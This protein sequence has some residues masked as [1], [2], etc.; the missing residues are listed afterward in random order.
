MT[1]FKNV[2]EIKEHLEAQ[3]EQIFT[4]LKEIVSF[5]SV[6]SEPTLVE[7]Y[8]GATNWTRD[9][10]RNAGFEVSEHLAADGTTNFLGTRKGAEDAPTVLLYSHFD[11]VPAGPLDLW[12]SAPFTLTEREGEHG[13]RWY[14][15]GAADCKGNLVMHLAALRTVAALGG[16]DLNLTF[17]VEGSEE[18]GG[19]ALS[20]LIKEKPE[21]FKADVILI[22][23]SGNAAVGIPTLT[24][25]L[26]G[27][28]QL[29]VTVD[30]LKQ[31][32]HSG[33]Y[34][35]AA[36]D[37]VSALVRILDSIRDEQGRTVIDGVDTTATWEGLPYDPEEFRSDAGILA[38]VDTMGAEDNPASLVWARPAI[39]ITGLTSTP[40]AEAVNAVPATASAKL[41]LRVP[42]GQDAVEVA[43]KLRDHLI[44]H[45]PWGAKVEVLIDDINQPFSTDISGPAISTLAECLSAAY[46]NKDTVTVGSGGSIPLCTE[47]MEVNPQAE[48]ALYG[49]E[50]P[51]SVI[52]SADESVD[53]NEIRDIATAEALFLLNLKK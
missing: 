24:T 4:Q 17:V 12:S 35:G 14:G 13:M 49:V 51:L 40:V 11:V 9:A 19:G 22:A 5:N 21:L 20:D 47:L 44:N 3:R 37:A 38:G 48:L 18:M 10:I 15:R 25:S 33:Q 42:A 2:Q 31:A 52:H 30:T 23:D 7:D 29:T 27:G 16:T 41:N 6:H 32:V 28:G 53:P 46:E 1:S 8:Q 45:A 50:E 26:R 43:E 39:T 34:G 36:P